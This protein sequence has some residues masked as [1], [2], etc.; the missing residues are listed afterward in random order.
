[1]AQPLGTE[2]LKGMEGQTPPS[3]EE[4]RDFLMWVTSQP[5]IPPWYKPFLVNKANKNTYRKMAEYQ[6]WVRTDDYATKYGIAQLKPGV[7]E[8]AADYL[9]RLQAGETTP[10]TGTMDLMGGLSKPAVRWETQEQSGYVFKIGYD[11][12]GNVVSFDPIGAGKETGFAQPGGDVPSDQFGRQATW[13]ADNAEWRFPPDWGKDPATQLASYIPA[14]AQAQMSLSERMQGQMVDWYREQQKAQ[15]EEQRQ[16]R[17]AE[18]RANPASW[19]E[20]AS[21]AGETPAVQPWMQPLAP[22]SYNTLKGAG[23]VNVSQLANVS[24]EQVGKQAFESGKALP[25]WKTQEG[26][27]SLGS[28]PA[29]K[30]PSAQFWSRMTPSSREQYYGYEKARTGARPEDIDWRMWSA[31]PPSG[32]NTGLRRVK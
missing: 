17:L 19:L 2:K 32:A 13:D 4:L 16:Q 23:I 29:L 26:G 5:S 10:Q 8:K 7:T 3:D 22:E 27:E 25:G 9:K 14:E 30:N 24:P 15:L 12:D 28:L 20:Y 11:E 1:M 6:D 31:A 21:L 18:L